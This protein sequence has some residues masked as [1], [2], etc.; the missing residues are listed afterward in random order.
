M[1]EMRRDR[2]RDGRWAKRGSKKSS[3]NGGE[4]GRDRYSENAVDRQRVKK[5]M[6]PDQ[7]K[8]DPFSPWF[9]TEERALERRKTEEQRLRGTKGGE[10]EQAFAD[11]E[12]KARRREGVK[13]KMNE[14]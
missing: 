2:P 4:E 6:G 7:V 12:A 9:R 11:R 8:D 10:I 1:L 13:A 3:K 5:D 14:D